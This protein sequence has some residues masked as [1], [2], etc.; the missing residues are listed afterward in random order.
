METLRSNVR[1]GLLLAIGVFLMAVAAHV[2]HAGALDSLERAGVYRPGPPATIVVNGR[3]IAVMRSHVFANDPQM[4]AALATERIRRALEDVTKGAI[5]A[6]VY[7][8]GRLIEI[9][10]RPM[11]YIGPLDVDIEHGESLESTT[12]NAI[13][14]LGRVLEESRELSDPKRLWWAIGKT[15]ALLLAWLILVRLV[16]IGKRRGHA[17][18]VGRMAHGMERSK[19]AGLVSGPA[20]H[21]LYRVVERSFDALMWV[22]VAV[23]TYMWVTLTFSQFPQTRI[24]GEDMASSIIDAFLWVL[25]G[26]LNALP[27]LA[28]VVLIVFVTRLLVRFVN[29]LLTRFQKGEIELP[30]LDRETVYPTKRIITIILW[31][32]A[33]AIAYPYLP[34][35]SSEAFKG[36]S[37]LVGLMISIGTTGVI[38]QAAS[39]FILMYSRVLRV[40]EFVQIG[41]HHGTIRRIGYFNTILSTPYRE[42]VTIPNTVILSSTIVNSSRLN[43]PGQTASTAVTIGYDTPWRLVHSMLLEA[44]RRTSGIAPVPEPFVTQTAL[45]DF[46]VEYRLTLNLLDP[47]TRAA[48]LSALHANIQDVFNE[49]G[50]QIMSPHYYDDP[51]HA[52]VVPPERADPPIRTGA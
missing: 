26:I 11:L 8:D 44:A 42:Q 9:D 30:L 45:S 4:R 12:A 40:G 6:R 28:T 50:Q 46:Y 47:G 35:S 39:G 2:V 21:G 19:L 31:I 41:G 5:T 13:A 29:F 10:G 14:A 34:G 1:F 3:T 38:G 20:A 23:S 24:W 22:I 16:F 36:V 49:N 52:K 51:D 48:T 17:W 37:V 43:L 27:G 33:V 18:L 15:A 32:F 25:D 7:G